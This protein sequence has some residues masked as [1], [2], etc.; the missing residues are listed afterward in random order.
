MP[1]ALLNF[2]CY[3]NRRRQ[4]DEDLS[5]FQYLDGDDEPFRDLNSRLT[6]I[7]MGALFWPSVRGKNKKI[8]NYFA[9]YGLRDCFNVGAL[10]H[11][12][13]SSF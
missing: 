6:G 10:V 13:I 9:P 11:L 8:N 5:W 1:N 2:T 12:R 4:L 7:R 3:R